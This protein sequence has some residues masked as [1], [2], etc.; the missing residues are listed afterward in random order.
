[1][2][3]VTVLQKTYDVTLRTFEPTSIFSK[4]KKKFCFLQV[5]NTSSWERLQKEERVAD[6]SYN[7]GRRYKQGQAGQNDVRDRIRNIT[8]VLWEL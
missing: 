3:V 6:T 5:S 8:R 1:M 4:N 2:E 7:S